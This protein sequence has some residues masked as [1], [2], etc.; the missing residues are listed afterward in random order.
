M[1]GDERVWQAVALCKYPHYYEF[2]FQDIE[3]N[4]KLSAPF[5]S[6]DVEIVK[7]FEKDVRFSLIRGMNQFFVNLSFTQL[8]SV[9]LFFGDVRSKQKKVINLIIFYS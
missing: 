4:L 7:V 9:P 5:S 2:V 1:D 6:T 3:L 8:G